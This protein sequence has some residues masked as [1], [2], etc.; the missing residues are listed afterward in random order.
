M[1]TLNYLSGIAETTEYMHVR[2]RGIKADGPLFD[3]PGGTVKMAVGANYTTYNFLIT[4]T[5]TNPT[6]PTVTITQD[7]RTS[8]GLGGLC[9]VECPDLQRPERASAVAAAGVRSLLAS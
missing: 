2:E 6:N 3:L 5:Q 4:Q 8:R 7:P 9:P 1:T